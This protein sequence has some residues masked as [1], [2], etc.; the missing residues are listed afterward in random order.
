MVRRNAA[1]LKET[2]MKHQRVA[3]PFR[4]GSY[5]LTNPQRP[6]Q[7]T[8]WD[9]RWATTAAAGKVY[10]L[11]SQ[12][13]PFHVI[14]KLMAFLRS[15][16]QTLFE[17]E[18][19]DTCTPASRTPTVWKLT[20]QGDTARPFTSLQELRDTVRVRIADHRLAQALPSTSDNQ[21]SA[22]P[23]LSGLQDSN[24]EQRIPKPVDREQGI[25]PPGVDMQPE[26][27]EPQPWI[28]HRAQ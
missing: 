4:G 5:S 24:R 10:G 7:G 11:Y 27:R 15:K 17:V 28:T 8:V 21:A 16:I 6:H 23:P 13:Y 9:P 25:L 2:A 22:S 26:P 1:T 18:D 12:I 14:G 3:I 20:F 19:M